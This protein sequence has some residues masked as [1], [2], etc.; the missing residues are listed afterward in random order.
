MNLLV[1]ISAI[2]ISISCNKAELGTDQVQSIIDDNVASTAESDV[3]TLIDDSVGGGKN[4]DKVEDSSGAVDPNAGESIVRLETIEHGGDTDEQSS[5]LQN[6]TD[7]EK[8]NEAAKDIPSNILVNNTILSSNASSK[9]FPKRVKCLPRFSFTAIDEN[10]NSNQSTEK[11]L[12]ADLEELPK[13]KENFHIHMVDG[14][15]VVQVINSS[16]LG[17]L[18][19]KG[20][21]NVTNRTTEAE[22]SLVLF[23]ASWCPFSAAAAP[24]YNGL[25]RLFPDISMYAVDS[26]RHQGINTQ[27]GILALPTL[28][29]FHNAKPIAKF[30]QS[31]YVISNFSEFVTTF[32][33]L[34]PSQT[35]ELRESDIEGPLPTKA[36]PEPDY[37]LFVAWL[38][39]IVCALG[40]FGKSSYGERIIESV[41]NNWREAEIQHEHID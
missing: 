12:A 1:A 3:Q 4:E 15:T 33:T 35:I 40:Y 29:L 38:F 20:N 41:R 26:S 24:Q 11:D 9:T 14:D 23:Y 31:N 17:V 27:F 7:I 10:G 19:S 28:I 22:C 21:P 36:V 30:N 18:L 25:A 2:L 5:S 32:T 16:Y 8:N 39:T 37:Y 34:D 13:R 6:G